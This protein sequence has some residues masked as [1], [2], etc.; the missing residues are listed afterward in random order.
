MNDPVKKL[1]IGKKVILFGTGQTSRRFLSQFTC[2]FAYSVDNDPAKLGKTHFNRKIYS[3]DRLL[4]EDKE[5]IVIFVLSMFYKE[6]AQQLEALGFTE[7]LHF[8]NGLE[9]FDGYYCR[10]TYSQEGEDLVLRELV[11]H[12]KNGFY[13]DIG[14]YHPMK[15][16]NT[17]YFYKRG[18]RGINIEPMPNSKKIFDAIRPYD[19]N[20]ELGISSSVGQMTYYIFDKHTV[21]TFDENLALERVKS[22]NY[23]LIRKEL[24]PI[25]R[26]NSILAK[27]ANGIHIDFISID[28]EGHEIDVLKS[29]DWENFRPTYI[30]IE[31]LLIKGELE[32]IKDCPVYNY[33]SAQG[34]SLIAKTIRTCFYKNIRYC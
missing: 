26:L 22:A 16:S 4:N 30:L 31:S 7:Y 6:I 29:N 14:A 33:L 8:F 1:S 3:P 28:V 17:Y 21:N 23:K 13:V 27:Y 32:N 5:N 18:W 10:E 24:I 15:Y 9:F 34:Y 19:I 20:L 25:D 12:I 2:D 11:K